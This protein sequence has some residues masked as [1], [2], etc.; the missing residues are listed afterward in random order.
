M[1][2]TDLTLSHHPGWLPD[3]VALAFDPSE[4]A[5]SH[6]DDFGVPCPDFIARAVP[7]RRAEYLAGR[8]VARRA[9]ERLRATHLEVGTDMLRAPIWPRGFTGSITH[10]DGL[11][12]AV[13]V[14][15]SRLISVG[16]DLEAIVSDEDMRAVMHVALSASERD[17]LM[18]LSRSLGM[19]IAFTVAFSAKESFYKAAASTV[20]RVFEFSALQIV[21]VSQHPCVIDAVISEHL[22]ASLT[23]GQ[24]VTMGFSHPSPHLVLTSCV[25]THGGP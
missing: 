9:L 3:A 24:R 21:R 2:F 25:L 16:M 14:P 20:G 5:L 11:A 17:V 19:R 1:S 18:E 10:A 6:F 23:A 4:A 8:R 12:A 13:A 15:T 7:R 22:A